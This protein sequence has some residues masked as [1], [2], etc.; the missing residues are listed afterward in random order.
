M[1]LNQVTLPATDVQR[2]VE[3][4]RRLG[5]TPICKGLATKLMVAAE[6]EARRR[7]CEHTRWPPLSLWS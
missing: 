4:Y 6:A 7:G 3:Y 1:N 5:F 2:S